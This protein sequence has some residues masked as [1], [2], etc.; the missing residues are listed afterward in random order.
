MVSIFLKPR[1][2]T[3]GLLRAAERGAFRLCLSPEILEETESVLLRPRQTE[4]H[5]YT[6][7]AVREFCAGLAEAAERIIG[8]PEL[9]AVPDDPKDDMV[10]ATAVKAG[11]DYLVTGDKKH[12]LPLGEYRGIKIISPRQFLDLLE[13]GLADRSG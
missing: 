10:V 2:S 11:A 9:A 7:G 5:R 6:A 4:R 13:H 8:L 1:G 12:L 3:A